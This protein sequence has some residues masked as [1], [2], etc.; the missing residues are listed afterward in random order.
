[1]CSIDGSTV[2]PSGPGTPVQAS[3]CGKVYLRSDEIDLPLVFSACTR[4][5]LVALCV[6][7]E[8]P[9]G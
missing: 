2:T 9:Q 7:T 4:R 6:Y 5:E 8:R 3:S 1:M